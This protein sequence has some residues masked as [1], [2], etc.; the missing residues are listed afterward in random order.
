LA[1]GSGTDFA[2]RFF[3]AFKTHNFPLLHGLQAAKPGLRL[4]Y[5]EYFFLRDARQPFRCFSF[6]NIGNSTGLCG[7]EL[8]AV[9]AY[10]EVKDSRCS[11]RRYLVHLVTATPPQ[12]ES[13]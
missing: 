12:G 13:L 1:A 5:E 3:I 10:Q 9:D 11:R 4:R 7:I 6:A 8:D 2:N